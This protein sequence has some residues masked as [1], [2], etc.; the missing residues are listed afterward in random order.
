M[1]HALFESDQQRFDRCYRDAQGYHRRA[2]LMDAQNNG[3]SLV[4]NVAAI[5]VECYLIALCARFGEMPMNHNYASLLAAVEEVMPLDPALRADIAH[6][7]TLFGICS[8]DDYHHGKPVPEDKQI[9]LRIC[10]RLQAVL[11]SLIKPDPIIMEN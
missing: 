7:D 1:A 2:G 6:L 5:A 8:I 11:Q 4:F 10:D 3:H 9:I